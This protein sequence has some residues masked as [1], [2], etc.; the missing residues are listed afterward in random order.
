[1]GMILYHRIL[2]VSIVVGTTLLLSACADQT[3][4]PAVAPGV[5]NPVTVDIDL[6]E[7]WLVRPSSGAIVLAAV[8][9]TSP[10][11]DTTVPAVNVVVEDVPNL[12]T[13]QTFVELNLTALRSAYEE[14]EIIES[15]ERRVIGLRARRMVVEY[16]SAGLSL[17]VLQYVIEAGSEAIIITCSA[18]P[19]EFGGMEQTFEEIVGSLRIE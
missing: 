10:T 12:M 17:R 13:W 3:A 1:M 11:G 6:P 7:G 16:R 19:E 18:V 4:D 15:E 2:S 9:P 5:V 8:A 14:L